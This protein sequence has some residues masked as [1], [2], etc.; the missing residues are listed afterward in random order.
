[1]FDK[2]LQYYKK[3]CMTPNMT[4]SC[5]RPISVMS[6]IHSIMHNILK[7]KFAKL[8]KIGNGHF[9]NVRKSSRGSS[10][11]SMSMAIAKTTENRQGA[12]S[13]R[14]K[15]VNGNFWNNWKS[16]RGRFESSKSRQWK[17]SKQLKVVKKQILIVSK[18][19]RGRFES[20]KSHQWKLSKL[21]RDVKRP[22]RSAKNSL[23]GIIE[24]T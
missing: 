24:R 21:L 8:L 22:I 20:S 3:Y 19:L 10:Y 12:D 4:T 5:N 1:M 6:H 17:L 18:S 7:W 11:Y 9:T 14:L 13:N 23:N 2:S 16:S 15:F